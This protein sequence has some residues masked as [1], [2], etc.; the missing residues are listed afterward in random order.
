MEKE[1]ATKSSKIYHPF[2]KW[3]GGKRNLLPQILPFL[4]NE[5]ESYFEP[6][7]GGGAL[8]FELFSLG[9]LENKK[10]YLFDINAELINAYE[11]LKN[12]PNALIIELQKFKKE[13]SKEFY[14]EVREWDRKDNFKEID[15]LLRA[16]RFIYLN[17]T[18][19]N[20]L[21]RVNKEGYFNVPM[22]AYKDPKICDSE[23]ILNSSYALQN[24]TIKHTSYKEVLK[25]A[26]KFDLIYFDPPYYPLNET[27]SFTAYSENEFLEKEQKELFRVFD[28]LAKKQ[29]Q[30]FLSNS[31][32]PFILDL[33]QGYKIEIL[34]ANRCINSKGNKR[35]KIDEVLIQGISND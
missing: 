11:V 16:T 25:L 33:Y 4:P 34:K 9:R 14:Y 22:G 30:V 20:G 24:A 19:F 21:Y 3:A 10:A 2:I 7:L 12:N 26:R 8:F 17:K 18:C 35:S 29:V 28:T 13:H 32:T 31:N 27:S 6:F 1:R 5:F 23:V 15:S